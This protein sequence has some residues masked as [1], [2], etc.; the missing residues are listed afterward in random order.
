M[1]HSLDQW[2]AV[3]VRAAAGTAATRHNICCEHAMAEANKSQIKAIKANQ[4]D[5]GW[6]LFESLCA[7]Y[8]RWLSMECGETADFLKGSIFRYTS[9]SWILVGKSVSDVFEI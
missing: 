1:L 5:N 9:I 3:H 7:E 2:P 8:L 6:K 4:M